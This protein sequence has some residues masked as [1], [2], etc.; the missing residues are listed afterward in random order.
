MDESN[1]QGKPVEL[2]DMFL[3]KTRRRNVD[4]R[5]CLLDYLD[6]NA[7]SVEKSACYRCPV[8]A[9]HRRQYANS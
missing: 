2:E 8:G 6:A 3:C 9:E 7:F 1:G 5:Q 4:V